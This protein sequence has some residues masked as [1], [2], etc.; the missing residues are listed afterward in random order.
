MRRRQDE[1]V[2]PVRCAPVLEV[3]QAGQ[4]HEDVA[5]CASSAAAVL[6]R[7]TSRRRCFLLERVG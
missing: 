5:L 3:V 2:Q 6:E 4:H 1:S 7:S